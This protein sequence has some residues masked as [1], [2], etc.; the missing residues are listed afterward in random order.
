[1]QTTVEIKRSLMLRHNQLMR[2]IEAADNMLDP[3]D[4]DQEHQAEIQRDLDQML[5][6]LGDLEEVLSLKHGVDCDCFYI[7]HERECLDALGIN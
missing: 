1:M 6:K 2:D 4:E 5:C 7:T 3:Q